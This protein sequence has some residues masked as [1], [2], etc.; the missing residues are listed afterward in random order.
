[1]F[2]LFIDP[3]PF[4]D[5]AEANEQR[6]RRAH[7]RVERCQQFCG[8][9]F[10]RANPTKRHVNHQPVAFIHAESLKI[11]DQPRKIHAEPQ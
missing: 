6:S 10:D 3:R 9:T 11:G 4:V 2:G 5:S 1:M 7:G 8:P